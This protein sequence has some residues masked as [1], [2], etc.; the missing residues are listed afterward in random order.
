MTVVNELKNSMPVAR[1]SRA[2]GVP[3]SSIYCSRKEHAVNRKPRVSVEVISEIVRIASERTT[4]GYRRIWAMIRNSGKSVNIKTVRRMMRMN[5][6][7]LP[8]S[9]YK[10]STGRRYLTKP[11]APDRLWE[12][13]IH[14]IST[15][16]DGMVYLMSIKD[17][18]SKRWISYEISRS[19]TSK[20]CIRAVEKAYAMRFQSYLPVRLMLR[21]DNG[22]IESFHSSLKTECI[23]INDIEIFEDARTLMEYAF[24]DYNIVRPHSSIEYLPPEEFERMWNE[25]NHFREDF[26]EKRKVNRERQIRRR[27]ERKRR[28]NEN[29]S[30]EAQK[31]HK[32]R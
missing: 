3:G 19:C 23:W 32:I 31:L 27:E 2:A 20:D 26:L 12:T 13:D 28:L 25:S 30:M 16:R 8:F 4:Y 5:G 24:I 10:N 14:Y 1:I 15:A 11:D 18:F 29:V 22:D 6:L 21:T 7:A 17:C 9:K